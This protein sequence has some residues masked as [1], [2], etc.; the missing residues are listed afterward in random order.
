MHIKRLIFPQRDSIKRKHSWPFVYSASS[1]R[2]A[3]RPINE[4]SIMAREKFI[5]EQASKAVAKFTIDR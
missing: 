3:N 5:R 2:S 4:K 1:I